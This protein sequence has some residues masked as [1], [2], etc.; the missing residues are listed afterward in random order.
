MP[1]FKRV[2]R[3]S[4]L[5]AHPL[6]LLAVVPEST[7][8]H[9]MASVEVTGICACPQILAAALPLVPLVVLGRS[10]FQRGRDFW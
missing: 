9:W 5:E 2:Q 10:R 3:V 6:I 4:I 8:V 7:N 1:V